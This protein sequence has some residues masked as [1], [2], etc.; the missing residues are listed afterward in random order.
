MKEFL[1]M[2]RKH[3]IRIPILGWKI[4][5]TYELYSLDGKKLFDTTLLVDGLLQE[6]VKEGQIV[7]ITVSEGRLNIET[8]KNR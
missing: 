1:F 2:L 5:T 8:K 6:G 3:T 4:M 7:K